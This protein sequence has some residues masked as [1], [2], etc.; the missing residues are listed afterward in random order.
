MSLKKWYAVTLVSACLIAVIGSLL[1]LSASKGWRFS[2][3]YKSLELGKTSAQ[4][5]QAFGLPPDF[6]WHY[7]ASEIWYYRSHGPFVPNRECV[8]LQNGAAI[9]SLSEL[10]DAYGYVQLAFDSTGRLCAYTWIGESYNVTY[11]GGSV[12]GSHLSK[13]QDEAVLKRLEGGK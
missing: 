13:I 6:R 1:F 12:P 3:A 9:G 2:Q 7:K 4:V 5:Q 11:E 10:P 8:E